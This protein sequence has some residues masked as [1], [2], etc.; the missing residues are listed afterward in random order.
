MENKKDFNQK[1]INKINKLPVLTLK[2]CGAEIIQKK[3]NTIG[4]SHFFGVESIQKPPAHAIKIE[5]MK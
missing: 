4:I 5:L 3:G 2:K 1:K